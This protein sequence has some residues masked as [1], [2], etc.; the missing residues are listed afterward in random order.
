MNN[1]DA[2][3]PLRG[4]DLNLLI[5]LRA[6]LREESVSRAA[7][8][9]GAT[10]PTVSRGL[11]SLRDAFG[12]P[13]LVRT[14]RGMVLTPVARSLVTPLDQALAALDRL[15][16]VGEFDP[17][18]AERLFRVT[19]PDAIGCG[20]MAPL[21]AALEPFP[22]I[23]F[24]V[25]GLEGDAL[26]ALLSGR[27][28]LVVGAPKLDHGD[29]YARTLPLSAPWSVII[30]PRHPKWGAKLTYSAWLKS[31][32]VQLM[33]A[34]QPERGSELDR[35][36]AHRSE[37]R[38]VRV[39]VTYLSGLAELVEGTAMVA[40]LPTPAALWCAERRELR[41]VPHPFKGLSR[42]SL[43]LTWHAIHQRDEGHRWFR[44]LVSE[45]LSE[46]LS[47]PSRAHPPR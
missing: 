41:V 14:G 20:V 32:H 1:D 46:F 12:D 22:K 10:Q 17:R 15:N 24:S 26:G 30:G 3:V 5:T 37:Q 36:L 6:L 23:G 19:M 31:E 13:L 40:S 34:G 47:Q 45:H 4:L 35:L 38:N 2:A 43:H 9:L 11:A 27:T 7:V 21:R 29:L 28:E 33:P 44:E 42:L 8:A 16:R 25:I 39:Q 18:T